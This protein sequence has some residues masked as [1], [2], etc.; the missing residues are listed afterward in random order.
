[1][2]YTIKANWKNG[3]EYSYEVETQ[4][5]YETDPIIAA[6]DLL[7]KSPEVESFDI[8]NSEGNTIFSKKVSN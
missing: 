4:T 2:K 7:E 6:R 3:D 8:I 1:M 5:C